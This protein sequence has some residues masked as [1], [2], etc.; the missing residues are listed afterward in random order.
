MYTNER[1][2]ANIIK[3]VGTLSEMK[4]D[5][6]KTENNISISCSISLLVDNNCLKLKY[7]DNKFYGKSLNKQYYHFLEFIGLTYDE[8]S[9]IDTNSYKLD[10]TVIDSLMGGSINIYSGKTLINSIQMRPAP[11]T[12]QKIAFVG[13]IWEK[14]TVAKYLQRCDNVSDFINVDFQGVFI[15]VDE[16]SMVTKVLSI[17][18]DCN[19]QLLDIHLKNSTL[20]DKI[21]SVKIGALVNLDLQ[22]SVGYK[23]SNDIISPASVFGY[24]LNDFIATEFV[25]DKKYIEEILAEYNIKQKVKSES[26]KRK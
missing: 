24:V 13:N 14:Y 16:K 25:Y 9:A 18:D 23:I 7:F 5:F 8:I 4:V 1:Y 22:Y 21:K 3:G 15:S 17:K 12:A 20:F 26:N 11:T 19:I 6:V 10:D 2:C